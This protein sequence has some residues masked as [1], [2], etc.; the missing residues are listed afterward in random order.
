MKSYESV[1]EMSQEY[2]D[3]IV[4]LLFVHCDAELASVQQL[5]PWLD[6]AKT[7][8]DRWLISRRIT[9]AMK[10]GMLVCRMLNSLN[11][12]KEVESL[13]ALQLGEH[14]L[15]AFNIALES[16]ADLVLYSFLIDRVGT[17]QLQDFVGSSYLPLGRVAPSMLEE[18]NL[19][20]NYGTNLM[21]TLSSSEEGR[22]QADEALLK[23][24]PRALDM[25]GHTGSRRVER[26]V[27]LGLKKHRNEDLRKE[28]VHEVTAI[29]KEKCGLTAPPQ[30]FD[31]HIG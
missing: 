3:Q 13:M 26:Y 19:H 23:W 7:E 4:N 20:V 17:Y 5:K 21:L 15:E 31:R 16:W 28:F 11:A 18:K 12:Q 22:K 14:K 2:R 10:H 24:Y 27:E 1:T 29:L 30:N 6:E 9:E 25:F 8:D